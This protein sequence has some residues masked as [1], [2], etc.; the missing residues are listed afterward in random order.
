MESRLAPTSNATGLY[1]VAIFPLPNS[2]FDCGAQNY[3]RTDNVVKRSPAGF[4]APTSNYMKLNNI[5]ICTK[6]TTLVLL[7]G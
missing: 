5:F 2:W 3:T 7:L 4:G 6:K 1:T